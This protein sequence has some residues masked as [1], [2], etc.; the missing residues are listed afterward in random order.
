MGFDLISIVRGIG[1]KTKLEQLRLKKV[2]NSNE[3]EVI[4]TILKFTS[5]KGADYVL[6]AVGGDAGAT[7]LKA[8]KYGG[9]FLQYGLMSGQQLPSS[10]FNEVQEKNVQFEFYHL[11][12]WVYSKPDNYRQQVFKQMIDNF[13]KA[14]IE[15]PMD[16]EYNI[17]QITEAVTR[18]ESEGRNGKVLLNFEV[19]SSSPTCV[20]SQS[21][22]RGVCK[23]D[24]AIRVNIGLAILISRAL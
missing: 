17:D 8:V 3:E 19:N 13:I 20:L 12:D 10:F 14:N 1:N 24:E 22:L 7:L 4:D 18:A 15:M 9:K 5:N 11:R 2:I 16:S 6:D 23:H 21:S